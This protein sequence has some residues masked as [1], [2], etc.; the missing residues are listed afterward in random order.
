MLLL[1]GLPGVLSGLG[2]PGLQAHPHLLEFNLGGPDVLLITF[3]EFQR[4]RDQVQL[5]YIGLT[6]PFVPDG[7]A[8]RQHNYA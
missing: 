1:L 8:E 5:K 6:E 4:S 3:T 2:G 7:N